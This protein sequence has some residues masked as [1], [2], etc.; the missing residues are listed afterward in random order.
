MALPEGCGPLEGNPES[1]IRGPEIQV[2][3]EILMECGL[4]R[5]ERKRKE[6]DAKAVYTK[7]DH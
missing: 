5:V 3:G 7:V 1:A 6:E 4:L 2:H